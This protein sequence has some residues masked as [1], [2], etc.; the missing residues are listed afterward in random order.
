MYENILIPIAFDHEHQGEDAIAAARLLRRDDASQITLL[1]IV[2]QLPNYIGSELPADLRRNASEGAKV[3]LAKIAQNSGARA[4]CHVLEGNPGMSIVD[5]A[6]NN[7]CDLII[8][9]SHKPG[10]AD[11][12]LGSTA[13]RVVRHAPCAVHIMR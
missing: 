1:H 3:E 9:A 4:Q 7:G 12:F 2:E 10:L 8:L 13:A 6:E 5:F 11:Y